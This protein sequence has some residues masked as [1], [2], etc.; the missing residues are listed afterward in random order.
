M[1]IDLAAM[2]AELIADEKMCR[3]VYD[4]ANDAIIRAGV[5]VV[6]T[7]TV[8]VGRNLVTKGINNAESL[9]LLDNDIEETGAALDQAIPWWVN[10]DPVRQRGVLNM[11]FNLGVGGLLDFVNFLADLQAQNWKGAALELRSSKWAGQVGERAVR[12]ENQILNGATQP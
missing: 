3:Q 6:G 10:L 1:N 5:T 8:G 4:D 11:A 12:I 2:Q 7:P 9:Y